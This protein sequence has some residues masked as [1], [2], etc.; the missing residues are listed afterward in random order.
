MNRGK[1]EDLRGE[2][3]AKDKGRWGLR[4]GA[5]QRCQEPE[6]VW[7]LWNLKWPRAGGPTWGT[8]FLKLAMMLVLLNS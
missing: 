6:P 1:A 3:G 2:T 8:R 5:T 4:E 7:S